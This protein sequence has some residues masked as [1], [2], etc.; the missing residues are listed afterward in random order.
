LVKSGREEGFQ[1]F[2][3]LKLSEALVDLDDL[4]SEMALIREF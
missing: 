2:L 1:V 3:L 4:L